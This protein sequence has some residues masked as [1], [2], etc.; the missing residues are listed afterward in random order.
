MTADELIAQGNLYR[1]Q[2]QPSQAL[3]CYAQAFLADPNSSAAWNNYGNVLRECG[4]P[5]RSIPFL[6][7]A[8]LLDPKGTTA[9]FNLAVSYLAMGNLAQGWQQYEH[10]WNFEHLAGTLPKF[11][12]PRWTG[13]NLQGKHILVL[14]EQ[15]HGDNIQFSRYL[16][17]LHVM[18]AEI[19]LLTTLG[20]Q[21]LFE[22]SA[23]INKVITDVGQ[24]GN[25]DF[26]TPLLT[27]PG[28]LG[29]TLE[30]MPQAVSYITPRTDLYQQWQQRLGAKNRMRVGIAWSGRQDN[31]LNE[32][33]GMSFQ[34]VQTL[35]EK[36]PQVQWINL[37][38][39]ATAQQQTQ[40]ESQGVMIWPGTINNFADT[41]ALL[42]HCDLV[43]SVDTAVAHLAAAQGRPTWLMLN[44][45]AACWRW[46]TERSDSPW[47]PTMRIF[48]QPV[49]D[50]WPSVIAKVTQYLNWFKV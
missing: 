31:W 7:H 17:N 23:V 40:L 4:Q 25:F 22:G 41:A 14:G 6:Q 28:I 35:I 3:Q 45:F 19:T 11:T 34:Q 42:A 2:H 9:P 43:I 12:Q 26:W 5:H 1:S 10:R 39:D 44:W 20:L 8:C 47:Y 37:Q 46:F 16:Y 21:S 50:D 27:I 30:N 18:G 48:R 13:Q 15:G 29:V 49:Q 36:N 38:I 24:A 32:H 33:K